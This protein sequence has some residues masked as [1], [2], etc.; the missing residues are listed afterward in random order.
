MAGHLDVEVSVKKGRKSERI[1]RRGGLICKKGPDSPEG[2]RKSGGEGGKH[3]KGERCRECPWGKK[4]ALPSWQEVD[5]ST[6][7]KKR[8]H[9]AGNP[10]GKSKVIP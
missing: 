8:G 3:E 9:Y 4:R 1:E 7:L 5:Q 6:V 2:S 10:S